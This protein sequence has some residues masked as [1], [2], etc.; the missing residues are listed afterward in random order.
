M[1]QGLIFK[2]MLKN[3]DYFNYEFLTELNISLPKHLVNVI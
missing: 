3:F 2:S 1:S